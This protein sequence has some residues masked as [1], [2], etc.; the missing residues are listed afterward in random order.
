[1]ET[2]IVELA[3]TPP[4]DFDLTAAAATH[5]RGQYGAESFG[6]GVFQRLLD[7]SKCLCFVSVY[8][9]GTVDIPQLKVELAASSLDEGIIAE[10]CR[11]VSWLLGIEQNLTPFYNMA[12]QEPRLAPLVRELWGLHIP[13]TV[14]VYEGIV[15]AIVG[16]QVNSHV[17]RLLW[18]RL[19]QTFGLSVQ[20]ADVTY[21]TFP[22]PE[23]LVVAG[24]EGLRSV[25]LSTRKAEYIL[26]ISG[27]VVS[28]ELDLEGL[29]IH[30]DEDVIRRLT[31][32]RGVGLWT[33]QWLLI[34]ALGRM[35]GFPADDLALQRALGILLKD[36]SPLRSEE[37]L[38]YSRRWSPFRSYVTTYLF[39]AIRSN[40]LDTL[41]PAGKSA[42]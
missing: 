34:H 23:A 7:L 26:D 39:A 3:A 33:A 10:A 6:D 38:A 14:S 19:I 5:F 29:R 11:Q 32:L 16:Q 13:R 35:D 31:G 9:M 4:Y 2:V 41:F 8:S 20:I 42:T 15:S 18:N 21:H 40:R 17:A 12:L 36:G 24:V 28:G 22:R 1:L 37:A 30:S 27:R 25:G